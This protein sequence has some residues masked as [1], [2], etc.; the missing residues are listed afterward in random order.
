MALT[1]LPVWYIAA[2]SLP[3][4]ELPALRVSVDGR[5]L[6]TVAGRPVFLLA[7]TAWSLALRLNRDDAEF[8]L[9][10]R[11]RQGFNAVTFVL[12]A[13]GRSELTD[14]LA[15]AYGDLPFEMDADRPDPARPITTPGAAAHDAI[16]YD[17]W[18]HVDHL[19]SVS[20][21]L[22][23][24]AIIL[25]T[26]GTGIAGSYDGKNRQDIVFTVENAGRYGA[27]LAG[28][29]GS[30]PHVLWMMGGDRS[31]VVDGNDYRPA[32]RAMASALRRGAPTALIS[33][34]PRK[35]APQSAAWFHDDEWLAFNSNQEWP[36]QQVRCISEDWARTPAKPTWLFEGR[37]E[38]YWRG[39]YKAEQWGEWQ[40]RQQAYQTIFAGGFGHT[41]GH[42]RVF[43][44]GYDKADWKQYMETPGVRS[45]THLARLMSYLSPDE[46]QARAPDQTLVS[47]DNPKPERLRSAY[48][49]ALRTTAAGKVMFYTAAGRRVSAQ[50]DRLPDGEYFAFWFNP[51]DGSW[52][53]ETESAAEPIWFA[54]GVRAGPGAS[55]QVFVPPTQGD[56]QDWVLILSRSDRL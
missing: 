19:I 43:G 30:E 18:D 24:Y 40:V 36:D 51:R 49:A 16:Q 47:G 34:H 5:G 21:R 41:Y 39:N 44:F 33:Y 12:F 9:E 15:N 32:V 14:S 52:A 29:Y 3:Q 11:K 25:P 48:V 27:W 53:R 26:W 45:V 7:D 13:P 37:Y 55:L 35:G 1:I 50:L 28:R 8:Y 54:R 17:Y 56:G 22:G 46:L 2:A 23:L 42:E 38:G 6:T 31:A 4:P 20:R 10:T